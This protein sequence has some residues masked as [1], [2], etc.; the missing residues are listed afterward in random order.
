MLAERENDFL[1]ALQSDLG[2]GR[3]EALTTELAFVRSEAEHMAAKL[4]RWTA[5]ERV[6]TPWLLQPA[7]S[8]IIREPLGVVLVIGAWNMP[9]PVLLGPV[10]AALA[11]GNAVVMKPSELAPATS[12]H[13]RALPGAATLLG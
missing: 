2:K 4:K 9:V 7:R 13:S 10:L 1:A 12:S 3:G 5:P 11:A 6:G 8:Q